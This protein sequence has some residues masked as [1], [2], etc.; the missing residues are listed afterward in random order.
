MV[1][2]LAVGLVVRW[3]RRVLDER[4]RASRRSAGGLGRPAT[5]RHWPP[6]LNLPAAVDKDG[7][8]VPAE[9]LCPITHC[10][11]R[12][13]AVV[14]SGASYDRQPLLRWLSAH[15]T[16]P[17]TNEPLTPNNVHPNLNLRAAIER[18]AS[19]KVN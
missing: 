2:G 8:A 6:P 4:R 11:M 16:D 14:P 13:P 18:W 12:D 17:V 1:V 7:T 10:A 15:G 5:Q 3:L 9:F 19:R